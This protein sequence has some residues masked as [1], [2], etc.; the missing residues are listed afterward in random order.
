MPLFMN[1]EGH[2]E[3]RTAEAVACARTSSL[4]TQYGV[5]YLRDWF[6][7]RAGKVVVW[8]KRQ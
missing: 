1:I 8:L 4:R 2:I 7:E 6:D 3:A 5:T